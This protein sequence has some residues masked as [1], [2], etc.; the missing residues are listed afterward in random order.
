MFGFIDEQPVTNHLSGTFKAQVRF[1]QNQA[2]G[3][4]GNSKKEQQRAVSE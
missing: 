2:V 4:N 3:A 1:V